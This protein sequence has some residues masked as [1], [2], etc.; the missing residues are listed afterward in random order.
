MKN[1]IAT[2]LSIGGVLAAFAF[3]ATTASAAERSFAERKAL[4][5]SADRNYV[6]VA[7]HRA[8]WRDAPENSIPAIEAAIAMGADMVEIDVK[9]T[10]DGVYVLSHDQTV[11]RCTD[12]TGKIS[13]MTFEELGRLNLK[14]GQGGRWGRPTDVKY[15][16]LEEALR[17]TKGRIMVN[18]DHCWN[19]Q[20]DMIEMCRKVGVQDEVILKGGGGVKRVKERDFGAEPWKAV[21]SGEFVYMPIVAIDENDATGLGKLREWSEI[22][23]V[24]VYEIVAKKDLPD[25]GNPAKLASKPRLWINTMWGSLCAGHDDNAS[26]KGDPAKDGWGWALDKGATVIQTDNPRPLLKWL[27]SVGRR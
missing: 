4:F 17:T 2:R 9:R 15:P 6:F 14:S 1:N 10:K 13:E 3:A 24:K 20:P 11:D 21:E 18:L 16:T 22:P 12:A 25:E 19:F 5:R 27:E 23:C 26:V 7:L 8:S